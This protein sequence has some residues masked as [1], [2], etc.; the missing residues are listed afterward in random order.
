MGKSDTSENEDVRV[1]RCTECAIEGE[2]CCDE[3]A[4]ISYDVCVFL[5]TGGLSAQVLTEIYVVF[6][7]NQCFH[8]NI[9]SGQ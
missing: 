2:P 8:H 3:G 7:A 5:S 6:P 1:G 4:G 9:T